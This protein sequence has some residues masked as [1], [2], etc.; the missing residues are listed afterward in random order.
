MIRWS[1]L[2]ASR[3]VVSSLSREFSSVPLELI[4]ELR[5][6]T[7]ASIQRCKE[8]LESSNKDV[9]AA[10]EFLRARGELTNKQR[11]AD[12]VSSKFS[13]V[14]SSDSRK[15]VIAQVSCLTDFAAQS[16]L[17]VKF[18]EALNTAMD[19]SVA[20]SDLYIKESFSPQI[21]SHKLNDVLSDL[22]AVLA[23]PVSIQRVEVLEGD[24]LGVYVHA[25]S[26]YSQFVGSQVSAVALKV[27]SDLSRE[28][29]TRLACL[30]NQ[31][32][33]QILAMKPKY[34]AEQDIPESVINK[35]KEI[36][37][38]KIT[39]PNVLDKAFKGHLAKYISDNSLLNMEWIIPNVGPESEKPLTVREVIDHE[40]LSI[41][42]NPGDFEI[43]RFVCM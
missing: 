3:R 36:L 39:N 41:G 15:I 8:A 5:K 25:K 35:E 40:C 31:I 33:R 9:Q 18:C 12:V 37:S 42:I 21:H 2:L 22:S 4:R 34:L 19:E 10:I 16:E 14:S 23:E 32:A 13:C 28:Q 11:V 26:A 1:N 30:A 27:Q 17:F 38:V 6:D 43:I 20:L 29:Q 24:L 7:G